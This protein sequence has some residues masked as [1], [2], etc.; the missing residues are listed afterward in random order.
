ML[1]LAIF[2]TVICISS[3]TV[4][5]ETYDLDIKSDDWVLENAPKPNSPEAQLAAAAKQL[6]EGNY[7]EAMRL[8][9]NWI[10][11]NKYYWELIPKAHMIHGDSLFAQK[12]YYESLFDYEIVARVYAGTSEEIPAIEKEVEIATMFAHGTRKLQWGMRI[13]DATDEAI[14]LLMRAQQR[15]PDSPLAEKAAMELA[16]LYFRTS[17]MLLANDMYDIFVANYPNSLNLNKAKVMSIRTQ[18]ATYRDSAFD[19]SGLVDARSKLVRLKSRNPI[20]A[21]Q[22]ITSGLITRIDESLGQKM[23]KTA[24]WYLRVNNPI[25]AEYTIRQL[26]IK[27][28]NTTATIEAL[29]RLIPKILPMLPPIVLKDIN[30]FYDVHQEVLLGKIITSIE[31]PEDKQ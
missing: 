1:K 21:S 14:E 5:Q 16:D 28:G 23:L 17:E 13:S 25:A 19:D 18:L 31:I 26:I 30:D 20:L 11:R 9:S 27:H 10:E 6:A 4:A 8:S 29:E 22:I 24:Q 15:L 12:Y 3:I 7:Q 2:F